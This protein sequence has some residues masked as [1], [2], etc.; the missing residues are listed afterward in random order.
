MRNTVVRVTILVGL[1]LSWGAFR[2]GEAG[3]HE[4]RPA[5][6]QITETSP[7][8]YDV[9][10]RT[11]LLSGL[12]FPVVLGLPAEVRRLAEPA[13]REFPGSLVERMLIALTEGSLAS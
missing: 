5:Y 12:P 9:V 11:P 3:A 8:R 6:L 2:T 13:S 4:S 7:Q 1:L 10:W